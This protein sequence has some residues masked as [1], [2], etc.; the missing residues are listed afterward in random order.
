PAGNVSE[1]PTPVNAAKSGF[2]R[3]MVSVE[4]PLF[5]TIVVGEYALATVGGAQLTVTVTVCGVASSVAGSV[6]ARQPRVFV[7]VDVARSEEIV[8]LEGETLPFWAAKVIVRPFS[9][10]GLI[11]VLSVFVLTEAV[12]VDVPPEAIV[13][14]AAESLRSMRGLASKVPL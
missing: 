14:G 4:N 9:T 3:V 2:V 10:V 7:Y 8:W 11:E 6:V 5:C 13:A 1:M 12:K